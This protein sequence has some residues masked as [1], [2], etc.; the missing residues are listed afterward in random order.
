MKR[1]RLSAAAVG[2]RRW[3][4]GQTIA[5]FA[6]VLL[7]MLV[8][9][10]AIIEFAFLLFSWV[11]VEHAAREGLRVA[12]TGADIS[13]N[14]PASD[15]ARLTAINAAVTQASAGLPRASSDLTVTVSSWANQTYTGTATANDP[16]NA[17]W[18]VQVQVAYTYRPVTP[19]F[20]GIAL[21]VPLVARERGLN[22]QYTACGT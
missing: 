4:R 16:G 22:E 10:L 14:S 12:I 18:A 21:A 6:L 2:R 1:R 13:G 19:F 17:C 7:P 11:L 15:A 3:A 9:F 8:S 20:S 5:E